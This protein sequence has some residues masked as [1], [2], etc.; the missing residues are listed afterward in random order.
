MFRER[1]QAL[2]RW[3]EQNQP[4]FWRSMKPRYRAAAVIALVVVAWLGTGFL[5]GKDAAAV[6]T[7]KPTASDIPR[8]RVAQLVASP[9]AVTITI[10][11]QTQALHAVDVRAQVD[12][13]VRAIHFEK[14][15]AVK[16]GDVLCELMVN[17]RQAKLD[18][19]TALV[20]QRS[21][22]NDAAQNLMRQG[23]MSV[24]GAKQAQAALES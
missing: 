7:A 17:D 19:A 13:I 16:A 8:V 11:G 15:D 12:G 2:R 4:N 20:S 3:W 24:T 23:A 21:K 5:S 6:T 1:M 9:R 10:R 14:G 22:E 18:E